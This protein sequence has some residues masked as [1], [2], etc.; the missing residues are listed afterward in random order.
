MVWSR[1][2]LPAARRRPPGPGERAG[3]ER[4]RIRWRAGPPDQ[5][6]HPRRLWCDERV[7]RRPLALASATLA[8]AV[9]AT[10]LAGTALPLP[11]AQAQPALVVL[12]LRSAAPHALAQQGT[13][14]PDSAGERTER[15][16]A[17]AP[18]SRRAVERWLADHGF[19][20]ESATGWTVTARGPVHRL[21]RRLPRELRAAVVSAVPQAPA[22]QRPHAV[23][24]G[25]SP[26]QLQLAYATTSDGR[27]TTI[28]TIQFSGWQQSD[29][30]VFARAAGIDLQPG[31]IA[32]IPVAGARAD[33]PDGSGGDF[34]VAFDVQ[35]ALGAAPAAR[36]R[37]YVAP[38]SMTGA[39]AVYD[40]V[41]TDAE[42]LGLTAVS[43]SWGACEQSTSPQLV[44]SLEQ[45][46]ARMVAAGTT[47]FAAS[48]DAGAYGC[49]APG[50][51]D[52]R[53]AVDYPASSPSVVAV[54]GTTLRRENGGWVETAWSDASTGTG[55][56]GG[57]STLF[58]RPVWQ[59]GAGPR[60]VPD[61]S[62]VA[63]PRTGIGVF[64]P[65]AD[66]RRRWLVAG[67]TSGAA[68][69]L[70]GGL[71]STISGL[72]RTLGF[73]RLHVPL[74]AAARDGVGLRDVVAGDN[75]RHLAGP[76]HDL[77][78]GLGSPDW[79]ALGPRLL[80]PHVLTPAATAASRVPVTAYAPASR[81]AR[82][83]LGET[84]EQACGQ[85]QGSP[86]TALELPG[87]DRATAVVLAVIEADGC[88]TTSAP[89]VLD[90]T[91]PTASARLATTSRPG[92]LALSWTGS[93]AGSGV[94]QVA[95][96]LRRSDTGEVVTSGTA[97]RS[98]SA[99]RSV[100]S[101]P[102]YVLEVVA[103]DAVGWRGPIATSAVA[104]P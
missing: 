21:T 91:A 25:W 50:D 73:G 95:W 84:V 1:G 33:V 104:T 22:R 16:A 12:T 10:T 98:G 77:A 80:Q 94:V 7:L 47:V 70:A 39:V 5:H 27:G 52:P 15:A 2:A 9:V 3:A 42:Q 38:N 32:T 19:T 103:T 68:P 79:T 99:L 87:A 17:V 36:Q 89:L 4:S 43:I 66:G 74:Y 46:L 72:G 37:V 78:T 96:S 92:V 65:D 83:G 100:P 67:G 97:T 102:S 24:T 75:L 29:A 54:G 86:P 64:G 6:S 30:Q 81:T 31:Q 59:Q 63:D 56:G 71:T 18:R 69:L 20:V 34:E 53:L 82:Y 90:R 26:E 76:G 85:Q 55:T 61:L 48:G 44:Q 23:P 88:R 60:A 35:A 45:S 58:A 14:P 101:G 8:T 41:A 49:G 11:S 28:A 93:D 40:A 51:P 62:A 13:R 57:L